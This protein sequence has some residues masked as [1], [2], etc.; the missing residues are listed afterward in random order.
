[1]ELQ[2]QRQRLESIWKQ[3]SRELWLFEGDRNSKIFYVSTIIR[4]R[5]NKI[6]SIITGMGEWISPTQ[7]TFVPSRC[8]ADNAI[9][10]QEIIHCLREKKKKGQ[11]W[12]CG[13]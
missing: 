5:R 7:S 9:I 10:A 6:S 11:S 12:F 13:S 3:K 4:R 2:E 1:M 8:I